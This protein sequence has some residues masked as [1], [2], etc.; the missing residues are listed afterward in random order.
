MSNSTKSSIDLDLW[1]KRNDAPEHE[2][3]KW[4]RDTWDPVIDKVYTGEKDVKDLECP[5]CSQ[6]EIYTFFEVFQIARGASAKEGRPV[7][8]ANRYFGCRFCKTQVRDFGE[9]PRWVK[10]EDINWVSKKA[11]EDAESD[12]AQ[13]NLKPLTGDQDLTTNTS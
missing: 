3:W 13:I 2:R 11:R 6:K 5:V 12:L 8:V 1:R 7:Y 10:D 4:A 9:V